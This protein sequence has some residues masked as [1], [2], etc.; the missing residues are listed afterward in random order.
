MP[1]QEQKR[2]RRVYTLKADEAIVAAFAKYT[3]LTSEQASAILGRGLDTVQ[4]RFKVLYQ[5]GYLNRVQESL[6][7]P[8]VYFLDREGAKRASDLG[9]LESPRYIESKSRMIVN[10]D[11]EITNFHLALERALNGKPGI[12][13]WRQWRDDLRDKVQ[14]NDGSTAIIPDAYFTLAGKAYFLEIV[15][16]YESEYKGGRSNIEQKL[17]LYLTYKTRFEAKYGIFDTHDFRVLWVL[18][19]QKRVAMLLGKIEDE[20]PSRKF[21]FTDEASYRKDILGKIW[22]TPKDFRD[23]TYSLF[24]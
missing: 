17:A 20:F 16:S 13:V 18:P 19:T 6:I 15:K 1:V 22:W 14:T 5:A 4:K 3:F 21:W 10:H 7:Q 8:Y 24:E 2:D 12:S 23:K 9:E 11:L